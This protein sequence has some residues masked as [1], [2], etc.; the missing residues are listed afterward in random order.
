M[1]A[2]VICM[3]PGAWY[4]SILPVLVT[5]GIADLVMRVTAKRIFFSNLHNFPTQ[6]TR[7]YKLSTY[8]DELER[9]TG[10]IPDRI[11]AHD[12]TGIAPEDRIE[13]DRE[14]PGLT[15]VP[16]LSTM[17]SSVSTSLDA[18]PRNTYQHDNH[19]LKAIFQEICLS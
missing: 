7:G 9:L 10:I 12:G 16:L 8:L 11:L 6:H 17:T 2:D 19:A 14:Y 1:E 5:P 13:I 15:V 18:I 4:T 3:G